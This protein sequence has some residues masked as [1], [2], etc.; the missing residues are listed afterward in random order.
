MIVFSGQVSFEI[1]KHIFRKTRKMLHI[2][3]SIVW[4]VLL[5][6]IVITTINTNLVVFLYAYL[7]MLPAM[8]LAVLTEWPNKKRR[9]IAT[10]RITIHNRRIEYVSKQTTVYRFVSNVKIVRDYGD[11]YDIIFKFGKISDFFVCQ[12]DLLSCGTLTEFEKVFKGKLVRM[13]NSG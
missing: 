2:I 8:N 5:V 10:S 9:K 3:V 1:E 4:F 12:K 13:K 6:P 11:Y 7:F